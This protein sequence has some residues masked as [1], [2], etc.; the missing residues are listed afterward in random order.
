MRK[1][2]ICTLAA[3]ILLVV[4]FRTSAQQGDDGEGGED[5]PSWMT[6]NDDGQAELNLDSFDPAGQI[7]VETEEGGQ[8]TYN[9]YTTEDGYYVV[10]AS[11]ASVIDIAMMEDSPFGGDPVAAVVTAPGGLLNAIGEYPF[12]APDL[13]DIFGIEWS[14]DLGYWADLSSDILTGVA[15]SN[16]PLYQDSVIFAGAVWIFTEDPLAIYT[17]VVEVPPPPPPPQVYCPADTIE[18]GDIRVTAEL[19]APPYPVVVGQDPAKRG[20]DLQWRVEIDPTIHTWYEE[21]VYYDRRVCY[22]VEAGTGSGCPGPGSRYDDVQGAD[23]W[24]E[25]MEN[26]S[27]W[28]SAGGQPRVECIQH[29]DVYVEQL[30]WVRA[31][32]NLSQESRDWILHGELQARYPG[33]ELYKPDWEF[34]P[35]A[36]GTTTGS[37]VFIWNWINEGTQLK[38]PGQWGLSVRAMTMGTPVTDPR[39]INE[40]GGAF[41][42]WMHEATLSQ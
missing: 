6:V 21:R 1:P 8:Q 14:E 42:M 32:A 38:D 20:A 36:G 27:N 35:G 7:T 33:A 12:S 41:D 24:F 30:S 28:Q 39:A 23:R 31:Q 18:R 22:S 25:W 29:V 34:S 19:V 26:D 37:G 16:N 15:N 2:I 4:P 11:T 9:T 3:M 5:V 10:I 40:V 17:E 13:V